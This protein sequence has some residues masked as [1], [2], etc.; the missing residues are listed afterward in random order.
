NSVS[1][2]VNAT[3]AGAAFSSFAAQQTFRIGHAAELM[4]VADFNGDGKPDLAAANWSDSDVSVLLNT[5]AAPSV[6]ANPQMVATG[7]GQAK[8]VAL[9]G[10]APNGDGLSFTLTANPSHGTL[11][12]F[13]ASTGA[14]TYTPNAGYT[15][16]DSFQFTVTDTFDGLTSTAA[17]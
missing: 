16:P 11:S 2:L 4:A 10:S 8:A 13:N 15:G 9:T 6:V 7:Q 12:G 1:V 14:V 3:P 17:T 5:T